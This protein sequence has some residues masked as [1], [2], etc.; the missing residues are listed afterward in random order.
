ML[1]LVSPHRSRSWKGGALSE[2]WVEI[3]GY[4]NYAVSNT[5]HVM[6]LLRNRVLKPRSN[7]QDYMKVVL[8]NDYGPRAHYV[9]RLVALCYLNGYREGI[10]VSHFDT[11]HTNNNVNNLRLRGGRPSE[12][13][14]P[15]SPRTEWGS[16]IQI[17]ETG[18]VFRSVRDCARYIGGDYGAIYA[19]LRGDRRKHLGYTFIYHEE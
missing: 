3:P 9:H 1:D 12:T 4:P 16:R 11:D 13:L 7:G 19:C 8:Y 17:V 5:G 10:H 18:E 15:L 6:N 14:G 2:Y